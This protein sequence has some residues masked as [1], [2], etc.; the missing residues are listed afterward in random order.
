MPSF[1]FLTFAQFSRMCL[2][3]AVKIKEDSDGTP[4]DYV[5]S[6]Q[7]GGALMS[8]LLSDLFNAPIATLTV[9]TYEN[10]EQKSEPYISQEVS[11]SI[12]G[13]SVIVV[14]EICDSGSTLHF[15]QNYLQNQAPASM[16][17]AVLY[18]KSHSVFTPDFW[19]QTSDKW[20]VFPGE[21]RE[22]AQALR[23]IKGLDQSVYDEFQ[24]YVQAHG[25]DQALQQELELKI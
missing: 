25:G 16:R 12:S 7:R 21:L 18:M 2:E 17:T 22:T 9:S 11:V 20:I 8:K 1:Q 13:K 4:I 14:D 19:V 10:M 15:V 6:I 24:S 5:I 3:L 23:T